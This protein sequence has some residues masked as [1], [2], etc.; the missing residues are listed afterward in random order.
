MITLNATTPSIFGNWLSTYFLA[1]AGFVAFLSSA[2]TSRSSASDTIT[3]T[4]FELS[5][6]KPLL[7]AEDFLSIADFKARKGSGGSIMQYGW[8]S[9]P[10]SE[11][12]R[13][14]VR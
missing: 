12:S 10:L 14:T 6:K 9:Q 7:V 4:S 13:L 5:R 8:L 1:S 3:T 11:G 2:P